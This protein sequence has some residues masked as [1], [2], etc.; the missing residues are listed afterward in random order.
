MVDAGLDV[1][2]C[3]DELNSVLASR[4]FQNAPAL[5]KILQYICNKHLEGKGDSITEWN[6]ALDALGR[7]SDFDP[8]KDSIVRVEL[9][10]LRKRLADFYAKEGAD[11]TVRICLPKRGYVPRFELVDSAKTL[12]QDTK[13]SDTA[14]ILQPVSSRRNRALPHLL[15]IIV[16][17]S[18]SL[19]AALL[20]WN[21]NGKVSARTSKV[22]PPTA[23]APA[24]DQ[25]RI[26]AGLLTP[27][28]YIDSSGLLWTGDTWVSGGI[29]FYRPDRQIAGTLDQEIFRHGR[30]GNFRYDIPLKPGLY[31]LHLHFAE[32]LFGQTPLDGAEARRCFDVTLNGKPLLQHFDLSDDAGGPNIADTKVF[33]GVQPASDGRLHL[34]FSGFTPLLNALE[35]LPDPSGKP[36][37]VRIVCSMHS[38]L[39]MKG[40]I[41]ES[42]RYFM[43]G[44][45]S[46]H[47]GAFTGT[48]DPSLY[49]SARFGNFSY[50]IPVVA[51]HDYRATLRF[52]DTSYGSPGKRMFDVF[53]NERLLL[54]NFDVV[55]ASGGQNRMLQLTFDHLRPDPQSKLIFRFR[56]VR[57]YAILRAIEVEPN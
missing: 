18:L 9:H 32:T 57:G 28:Q 13:P 6:I 19:C 42:D 39:D 50:S 31:E 55:K 16:M 48:D 24:Q 29:V 52:I 30:E 10:L 17:T 2:R 40:Q 34:V 3:R 21:N 36:L 46:D 12:E 47:G 5:S 15:L 38:V 45:E 56:P 20:M 35:I 23:V 37:P 25:I 54:R 14:S 53:C 1:S 41:W 4:T 26:L 22:V 44:R 51:G 7:S 8:E 33:D 27:H 11:H 49:V 43:G